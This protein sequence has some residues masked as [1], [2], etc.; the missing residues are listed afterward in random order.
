M[1]IK[2]KIN[3][4]NVCK[5]TRS[6]RLAKFNRF[7]DTAHKCFGNPFTKV[8]ICLKKCSNK[9]IKCNECYRFSELKEIK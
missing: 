5:T 2:P 6:E 7:K 4:D 3:K 1:K 9:D 8:G